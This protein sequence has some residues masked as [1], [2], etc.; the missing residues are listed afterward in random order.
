MTTWLAINC[1]EEM[2]KMGEKWV[3]YVRFD[4]QKNRNENKSRNTHSSSSCY[5]NSLVIVSFS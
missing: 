1:V 4:L 5:K 3:E 2:G